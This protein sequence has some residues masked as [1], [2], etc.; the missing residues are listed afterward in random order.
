MVLGEHTWMGLVFFHT[1][2]TVSSKSDAF[3]QVEQCFFFCVYIGFLTWWILPA[4]MEWF[5]KGAAQSSRVLWA[6][7]WLCATFC[8]NTKINTL[9]SFFF[10]DLQ[11]VLIYTLI[12][13]TLRGDCNRFLN[14]YCSTDMLN[15]T[16]TPHL[17]CHRRVISHYESSTVHTHTVQYLRK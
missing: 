12:V 8:K 7:L 10:P 9:I 15:K 5:R 13:S 14:I 6:L 16:N 4:L 3:M 17:F 11:D 2:T 1:R